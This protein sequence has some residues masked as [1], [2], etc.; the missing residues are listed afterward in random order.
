MGNKKIKFIAVDLQYDFTRPGG[1]CYYPRPSV[2]F[3]TSVILPALAE[4][5]IRV[6]EIIADYRQPR[7]GDPRDIC[8][9]GEWGYRSEIPAEARYDDIWIKSLNSPSWTRENAGD[10]DR[11]CGLP[12]ADH[13]NFTSW[14]YKGIGPPDE[15]KVV[16]FGLTLD[17]CVLCTAQE[18]MFRG[19]SVLILEEGTDT[20]SG[21]RT[22]KDY[23]LNRPPLIY[24][25]KPVRWK[26][27]IVML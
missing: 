12:V 4:R 5:G 22:E 11:T 23:L 1:A 10:P 24:W 18:L 16:L 25:A 17:C 3:I 9:P 27:L 19:Y 20:R 2:G 7:P 13:E 15:T 8:R 21:H 14:L 26:D 6:H